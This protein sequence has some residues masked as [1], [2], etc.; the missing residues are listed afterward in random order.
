VPGEIKQ[1]YLP[2]H[3][4]VNVRCPCQQR[5]GEI[6]PV[7]CNG[8]CGRYIDQL[9][10]FVSILQPEKGKYPWL[11]ASMSL[12]CNG[13]L[14]DVCLP[15]EREKTSHHIWQVTATLPLHGPKHNTQEYCTIG[16][17]VRTTI[18]TSRIVK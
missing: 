14:F 13:L 11:D 12:F 5:Y 1:K 17:I 6:L 8:P 10:G 2:F 7:V 3:V 18:L 15:V 9:L 4:V 16:V